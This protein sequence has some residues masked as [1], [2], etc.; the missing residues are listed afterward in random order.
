MF[1]ANKGILSIGGNLNINLR[2]KE[3]PTSIGGESVQ[4]TL[5][6]IIIFIDIFIFI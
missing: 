6:F 3:S 2:T 4:Y 1:C 5:I